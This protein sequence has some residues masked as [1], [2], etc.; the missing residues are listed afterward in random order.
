MQGNVL[1]CKPISKYD[2]LASF[3]INRTQVKYI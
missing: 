3:D 2:S 1:P